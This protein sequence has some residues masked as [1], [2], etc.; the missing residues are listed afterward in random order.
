VALRKF[1]SFLLISG[2]LLPAGLV[3]QSSTAAK[4]STS[5]K[6]TSAKSSGAKSAKSKSAKSKKKKKKITPERARRVNRAFKASADL[7]PMAQQLL[8]NRTP[9]AYAGVERMRRSG[10]TVAHGDE[11]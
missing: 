9:Q 8:S 2:F 7:R 11:D 3:G 5:A 1:I 6:S 10:T 4:K